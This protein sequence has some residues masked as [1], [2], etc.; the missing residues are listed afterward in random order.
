MFIIDQNNHLIAADTTDLTRWGFSDILDAVKA[1]REGNLRFEKEVA[2]LLLPDDNTIHCETETLDSLLGTW[3]LC[4]PVEEEISDMVPETVSTPAAESEEAFLQLLPESHEEPAAAEEPTPSQI[5]EEQSREA[6]EGLETLLKLLPEEEEPHAESG[7]E[8]E[9]ALSLVSNAEETPVAPTSETTT[10][11]DEEGLLLPEMPSKTEE[12][13]LQLLAEESPAEAQTAPEIER[14]Q[15]HPEIEDLL[16]L[17]TEETLPPAPAEEAPAAAQAPTPQP[18]T[19]AKTWEEIEAAF[20][21]DL[22]ANAANLGLGLN[23]YRTLLQD[24]IQDCRQMHAAL[25]ESD[26]TVRRETVSVMKDAVALLQL[27][28]LGQILDMIESAA[29]TDRTEIV[30]T[31][32]RMLERLETYEEQ[33][34]AAAAKAVAE[35]ATSLP[36]EEAPT[37]PAAAESTSP[38]EEEAKPAEIKAQA[39]TSAEAFLKEVKPI[40]INFSLHIA[41]EELNLPEDLVQE[42]I[43][44]FA[45]QGHEYLPVLIEAYEKKDLDKLQ[46]TA[47]MLKGAASNLRVEAMVENLYELQ[48]DNDIERAPDRI[49]KFYGQLISLDNFLKQLNG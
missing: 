20:Q 35:E 1:F 7:E 8:S 4:H 13:P 36:R 24:F 41:A 18:E 22:R 30:D 21:P 17:E 49:R 39:A 26:T 25:L 48:Y 47:H 45:N 9:A 44:D 29:P 19:E 33:A 40:P 11:S 27:K 15:E 12:A 10:P 3:Y 46:K 6:E 37:A 28:P 16:T 31:L 5:T 38:A 23:E 14:L 2:I 42:F 34:E 32:E 43:S